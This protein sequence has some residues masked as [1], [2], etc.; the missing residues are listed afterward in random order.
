MAALQTPAHA[1]CAACREL[2]PRE[3]SPGPTSTRSVLSP[4]F[5]LNRHI[6]DVGEE[7]RRRELH[8]GLQE[9]LYCTSLIKHAGHDSKQR[10]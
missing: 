9:V 6:A 3:S 4:D 2:G 5:R 1:V 7:E 10:K 8:S